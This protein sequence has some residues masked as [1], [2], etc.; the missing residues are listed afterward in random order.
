M[1]YQGL[2]SSNRHLQNHTDYRNPVDTRCY[3][4][5]YVTLFVRCLL[6][7]WQRRIEKYGKYKYV[8]LFTKLYNLPPCLTISITHATLLFINYF[9]GHY[10]IS[11]YTILI[12]YNT[13]HTGIKTLLHLQVQL[14]LATMWVCFNGCY[15]SHKHL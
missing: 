9:N 10:Y 4:V 13:V 3:T 2:F 7:T 8:T 5:N 14:Y 12:V 1:A 15:L 11:A 6:I